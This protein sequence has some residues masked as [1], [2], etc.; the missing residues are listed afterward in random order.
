MIQRSQFHFVTQ[1]H[2]LHDWLDQNLLLRVLE[3]EGALIRGGGTGIATL[4]TR[5]W[6]TMFL[7]HWYPRNFRHVEDGGAN[8]LNVSR[9]F[10][11]QG[12][13]ALGAAAASCVRR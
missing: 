5:K 11:V 3:R 1:L 10:G 6:T 8:P 7:G 4:G 12:T 13:P 2:M 9:S